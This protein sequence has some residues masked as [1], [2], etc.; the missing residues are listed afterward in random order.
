MKSYEVH[1]TVLVYDQDNDESTDQQL[2][3]ELTGEGRSDNL[4]EAVQVATRQVTERVL[5]HG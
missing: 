4:L 5:K 3:G 2:M 1:V